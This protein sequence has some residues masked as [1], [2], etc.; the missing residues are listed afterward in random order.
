MLRTAKLLIVA[1]MISIPALAH[2]QMAN[3]SSDERYCQK[4]TELYDRYVGYT[5]D[6]PNWHGSPDVTA[7][8]AIAK[9]KED[10]VEAS[11]PVLEKKLA[12]ARV[13]LPAQAY[14]QAR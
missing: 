9:C 4:L 6:G 2:A 14:S 8:V 12:D 13:S 3:T 7:G 1:G 10:D 5:Q 11:I